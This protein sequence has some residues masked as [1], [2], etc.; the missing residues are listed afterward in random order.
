MNLEG[1]YHCQFPGGD[2]VAPF[3]R[4]YLSWQGNLL[5]GIVQLHSISYSVNV[6][7][8]SQVFSLVLSVSHRMSPTADTSEV[9]IGR[10]LGK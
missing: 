9:D 8:E 10:L 4:C 2:I 5:Q 6:A 7:T 3:T 1:C